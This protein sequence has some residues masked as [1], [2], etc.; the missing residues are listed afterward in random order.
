[1][2]DL[3]NSPNGLRLVAFAGVF[4]SMALW[5]TFAPRRK[6]VARKTARWASNFGLVILSTVLMRILAP[7]GAVGAAIFA[8]S[9]GWGLLNQIAVPEWLRFVSALIVLDLAIYAQHVVFHRIPLLWRLHMVHHADLDCDVSTGLRFHTI[10]I[11][12]SIGIKLV[13][14][15]VLGISPVA[16][17]AFEILLNGTAMFNHSN[18]QL[19]TQLDKLLRLVVVTPDM[20]RVHHSVNGEETNSN[21]GFNLP[22]WDFLFCTYRSQP[23]RGHCEMKIGLPQFRDSRAASLPFMLVMPFVSEGRD[24]NSQKD[25]GSESNDS[26]SIRENDAYHR[27]T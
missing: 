3:L 6:L 5:E 16:V 19:P 7:A 4:A 18:V 9:H 22:W 11:L 24:T 26:T 12:L 8:Q 17:L 20:H 25:K 27:V 14:V 1:M 21:F 15:V 13:V 23:A 10:E 2:F